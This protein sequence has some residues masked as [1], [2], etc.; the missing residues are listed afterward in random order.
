ML[1]VSAVR[2]CGRRDV[3][4]K[5]GRTELGRAMN[6]SSSGIMKSSHVGKVFGSEHG[7][8]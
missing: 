7:L 5:R 4:F 6:S 3:S 2:V 8:I 1:R